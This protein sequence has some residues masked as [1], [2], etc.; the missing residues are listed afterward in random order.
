MTTAARLSGTAALIGDPARA[1]ILMA[2]L[3]GRALTATELAHAAGV[4]AQ[5]ASGH[6]SK[7]VD[8]RLL[9]VAR[10]GRHRYFRLA[11]PEVARML[12]GIMVVA[13]EPGPDAPRATPRIDPALRRA[14]T[15]YDHLAGRLGVEIADALV[16]RGL[17]VLGDEAGAATEAGQAWLAAFGVPIEPA[18]RTRRVFCRPCLDWSERRP[19]LAGRL[20]AA[21]CRRCEELGWITRARD[22]RAVGVTEAGRRGFERQFGVSCRD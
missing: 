14:R 8:G 13:D 22:G 1:N 12:E 18:G 10:Q 2:L 21:L 5:T 19:H 9:G 17:I 16:A 3:D 15:C 4:S 7:L 20:G 11:A 6:L